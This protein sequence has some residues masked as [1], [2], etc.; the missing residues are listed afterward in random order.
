MPPL[1]LPLSRS[2]CNAF[3]FCP[4][5]LLH[6]CC[7]PSCCL[8]SLSLP[9]P[10]LRCRFNAR[11]EV[12]YAYLVRGYANQSR[13]R[14]NGRKRTE[15]G[16]RFDEG[17]AVLDKVLRIKNEGVGG[18]P[19]QQ[20]VLSSGNSSAARH[21]GE[22]SSLHKRRKHRKKWFKELNHARKNVSTLSAMDLLVVDFKLREVH[23]A[24]DDDADDMRYE[25]RTNTPII[26]R[27]RLSVMPRSIYTRFSFLDRLIFVS[28]SWVG[29]IFVSHSWQG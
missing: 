5:V 25:Y 29:L 20:Q 26:I 15:S 4:W 14:R 11:D 18:Q 24:S 8:L 2:C 27:V 3:F 28:H 9:D 6:V 22:A 19:L 21:G 17:S 13:T 10:L 12:A 16:L 23:Y 1:C 7:V